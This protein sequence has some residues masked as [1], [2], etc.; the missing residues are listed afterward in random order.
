MPFSPPP[1]A[2]PPPPGRPR[3]I[4]DAINTRFM[5]G[6]YSNDLEEAGVL[7][8][9]ADW[10]NGDEYYD[11]TW[12]VIEDKRYS[13]RLA[14]SII[15]THRPFMFSTSAIGVI[16]RPSDLMV[17]APASSARRMLW[18]RTGE[19]IA[20]VWCSYPFDGGSMRQED[21]VHGCSG[22]PV[23]CFAP[24]L[25]WKMLW[26]QQVGWAKRFTRHCLYGDPDGV[27]R[28]GCGYNEVVLKGDHYASK[29]PHV[30]EAFFYPEEE[31]SREFIHHAEGNAERARA[32]RE[33]FLRAYSGQID[34]E[35]VPLLAFDIALSR[36]GKAPFRFADDPRP[37]ETCSCP[38]LADRTRVS[39]H[40]E[41][42]F[43]PM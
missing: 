34:P 26:T 33:A 14:S 15:N 43:C 20:A 42:V 22:D 5:K 8:R 19:R 40:R 27:D 36:D 17:D 37:S 39:K 7:I 38:D 29:L 23:T 6:S 31:S 28:S 24:D 25:L 18:P 12:R 10:M 16:L 9:Q 11:H 30:I 41:C 21:R 13:D 2:P 3:A 35:D 4:L 1:P 32:A